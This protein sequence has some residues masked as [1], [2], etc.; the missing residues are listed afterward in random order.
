MGWHAPHAHRSQAKGATSE[1][2]TFRGD[3]CGLGALLNLAVLF[4]SRTIFRIINALIHHG[5]AGRSQFLPVPGASQSSA[6][7]VKTKRTCPSS[8][9]SG[10]RAKERQRPGPKEPTTLLWLLSQSRVHIEILSTQHKLQMLSFQ[11]L[12]FHGL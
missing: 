3:L 5:L 1:P 2:S 7:F 4:D 10:T 12:L 9:V 8:S 11:C 6:V